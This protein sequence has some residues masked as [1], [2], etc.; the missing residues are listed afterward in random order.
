MPTTSVPPQQ[1]GLARVHIEILA[2]SERHRCRRRRETESLVCTSATDSEGTSDDGYSSE[3]QDSDDS[4]GDASTNSVSIVG[5]TSQGQAS[6][7][8]TGQPT[9]RR[10]RSRVDETEDDGNGNDRPRKGRRQQARAMKPARGRFACPYQAY[11]PWRDCFKRSQRNPK[12]GCSSISRLKDHM[13]RKHMRSYRCPRCGKQLNARHKVQEHLQGNCVH[14]EIQINEWFMT[15]EQESEVEN[16]TGTEP[17]ETWW[18][19]FRLLIPGMA[20]EDLLQLKGRYFPYYVHFDMSLQMPSITFPNV[21]FE[22]PPTQAL[23]QANESETLPFVPGAS[24]DLFWTPNSTSLASQSFSLPI[25]EAAIPQPPSIPTEDGSIADA[26]SLPVV[27]ESSGSNSTAPNDAINISPTPGSSLT[28]AHS[29]T[30]DTSQ[31]R[32]NYERLR[33]RASQ[34]DAES[35]ELRDTVSAT[36]EEVRTAGAI[37]E[38]ILEIENL[39]GGVHERLSQVA[40]ILISASARL[41]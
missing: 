18:K 14:E 5:E 12:G 23:G 11:Q 13:A 4:P 30:T 20:T 19:L 31:L 33:M 34:A 7:S 9:L 41:R 27:R 15:L 24:S 26:A 25:Y 8:G 10:K 36:R 40:E 16:C 37:L 32:R 6:A 22:H 29:L 21:S 1:V 2:L 39:E 17:E 3:V 38:E 35:T 28:M